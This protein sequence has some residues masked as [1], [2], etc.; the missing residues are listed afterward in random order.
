LNAL[1]AQVLQQ[2]RQQ[3]EQDQ[4]KIEQYEARCDELKNERDNACEVAQL[5][6][7]QNDN[8]QAELTEA[9]A[10]AQAVSS[11]LP[12][13]HFCCVLLSPMLTQRYRH[14]YACLSSAI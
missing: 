3:H 12:T 14:C 7:H 1:C 2:L 6:L 10:Q 5:A 11:Y 9:L 8:I 13:L 4:A